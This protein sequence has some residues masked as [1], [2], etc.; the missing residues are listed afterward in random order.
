MEVLLGAFQI[1]SVVLVASGVAKIVSPDGFASLLRSLGLPQRRSMAVLAGVA[2]VVLGTAALLL[3]GAVLAAFVAAAY[4]VFAIVV[5]LARRSGAEDC[6]CFGAASAPPSVVH[7]VVNLASG[8]VAAAIAVSGDVP[9]I[10]EVLADQPALGLPY[11]LTVAT[12]AWLVITLDTVAAE[13]LDGIG[14]VAELGPT[15][16]E[17]AAQPGHRHGRRRARTGATQ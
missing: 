17:S 16:R 6:G 2:E 7:V 1:V 12:G 9:W 5:V 8:A 15:F 4:V 14:E 11:L 10:G 3:G 13:V